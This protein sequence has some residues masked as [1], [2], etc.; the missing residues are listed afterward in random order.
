MIT[1]NTEEWCSRRFSAVSRLSRLA[2]GSP[3]ATTAPM[4]GTGWAGTRSAISADRIASLV[5]K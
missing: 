4:S 5:G 3:G 1:R 2:A